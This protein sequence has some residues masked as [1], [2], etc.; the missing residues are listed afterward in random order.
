MWPVIIAPLYLSGNRLK[1]RRLCLTQ[2]SHCTIFIL[3]YFIYLCFF[4][5]NAGSH[6]D[7][8]EFSYGKGHLRTVR[9]QT[10]K[11]GSVSSHPT[12]KQSIIVFSEC[13]LEMRRGRRMCFLQSCMFGNFSK[14]NSV[15]SWGACLPLNCSCLLSPG[16]CSLPAIKESDRCIPVNKHSVLLLWGQKLGTLGTAK[17]DISSLPLKP[18]RQFALS[19]HLHGLTCLF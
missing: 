2:R 6:V 14:S 3:F 17:N 7:E 10:Y 4:Y 18:G 13:V 9:I 15:S 1:L 16:F 8:R 12:H 19:Q 5:G 11:K